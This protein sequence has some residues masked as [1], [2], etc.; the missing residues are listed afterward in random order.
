MKVRGGGRHGRRL[1]QRCGDISA[2]H[3]SARQAAL[4]Q[5]SQ[6]ATASIDPAVAEALIKNA[7]SGPIDVK[8]NFNGSLAQL[9]AVLQPAI[10][11]ETSRLGKSLINT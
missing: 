8:I 3:S 2:N 4:E 11:A 1:V 9:A 6:S 7:N 10:T 5:Q